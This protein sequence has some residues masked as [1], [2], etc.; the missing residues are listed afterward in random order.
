[1]LAWLLAQTTNSCSSFLSNMPEALYI[2]Y[3]IHVL[4]EYELNVYDYY[5][6]CRLASLSS[7]IIV[8]QY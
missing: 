4:K 2:L 1:M 5:F 6:M 8:M 7:I 3:T